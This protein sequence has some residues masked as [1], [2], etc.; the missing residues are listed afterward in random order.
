MDTEDRKSGGH[1][2]GDGNQIELEIEIANSD[3]LAEL[4]EWLDRQTSTDA[5]A[6]RH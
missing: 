5:D 6:T 3:V 1:P 2:P 4:Q